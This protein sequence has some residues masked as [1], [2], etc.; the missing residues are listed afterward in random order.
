MI[1][2]KNLVKRF[3]D[4]TALDGL[5][6]TVPDGAIYGL[7][8]ANGA[9]KSTT[10]KTL[11]GILKADGGDALIDGKPVFENPEVKARIAYIPDEVWSF[12]QATMQD[13]MKFY[14]SIYPKFDL[15]RWQKLGEVFALDERRPIRK[16]SRGMKKQVAFRLA[17][18][19]R[20]DYLF[21][22]EPVDGLD[23]MMRRQVW[24]LILAD[25]ADYGTT[26][27]V[28]SHNLRELEEICDHVGIM[29]KGKMIAEKRVEGGEN[30]EAL[31][32]EELGGVQYDVQ[33]ILL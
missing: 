9:G 30:L 33:N 31:F 2:V 29:Q 10:I 14:R 23:P 11:V 19:M 6:M 16:F 32:L 7:V 28:S 1:E 24:Q 12:P 4:H 17:L 27:L 13:M 18:S 20:A 5:T 26:V 8:G 15:G 3:D 25:S 22:D 21:L